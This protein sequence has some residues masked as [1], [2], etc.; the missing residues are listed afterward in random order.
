MSNYFNCF[1][2]K[3]IKYYKSKQKVTLSKMNL[4]TMKLKSKLFV[5]NLFKH[6]NKITEVILLKCEP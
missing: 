3:K 5:I 2:Q 4:P 6:L 1:R